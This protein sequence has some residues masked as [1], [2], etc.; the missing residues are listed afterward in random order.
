MRIK[1]KYNVTKSVYISCKTTQMFSQNES[2][3]IRFIAPSMASMV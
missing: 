3:N 1:L 2:D